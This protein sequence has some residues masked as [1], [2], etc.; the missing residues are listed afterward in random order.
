MFQCQRA[1]L[2]KE[3][4]RCVPAARVVLRDMRIANHGVVRFK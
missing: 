4:R 2:A 1:G 3:A